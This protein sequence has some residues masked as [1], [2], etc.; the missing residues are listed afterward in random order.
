MPQDA[1][2][3]IIL[4]NH[5]YR[6]NYR[7]I[8]SFC[9]LLAALA[10]GELGF[11]FFMHYTRPAP[12]YFATTSAGGLIEITPLSAP[13]LNAN[14]LL[15][16]ATQAA[17]DAYTFNFVDYKESLQEARANFTPSGYQSFLQAIKDSNILDDVLRKKLVVSA[18]PTN[19]P[20]IVNEGI[21]G[22]VYAWRVQLPMLVSFQSSTEVIK[23]D[24]V[25]TMLITRVPTLDSPQGIGIA[26]FIVEVGRAQGRNNVGR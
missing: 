5:F 13:N 16:W 23:Q 17:T 18:V 1:L 15:Q 20:V 24:V 21:A 11:I 3:T 10:L 6:D 22:D 7:R 8:V 2:E 9:L 4:R 19:T 26:Q 12:T 14:A 25:L